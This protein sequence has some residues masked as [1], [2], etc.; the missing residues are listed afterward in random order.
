MVYQLSNEHQAWE[1]LGMDVPPSTSIESG[2]IEVVLSSEGS[3]LI[4]STEKV[5]LHTYTVQETLL[6]RKVQ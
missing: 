3:H 2:I 4:V 6:G 5:L 1:K